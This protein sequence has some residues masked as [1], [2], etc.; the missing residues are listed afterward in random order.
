MTRKG[1]ED[2][3]FD[4]LGAQKR[5]TRDALP[6]PAP[7]PHH[8]RSKANKRTRRCDKNKNQT[9][10]K[11][12]E[13][14]GK[15]ACEKKELHVSSLEHQEEEQHQQKVAYKQATRLE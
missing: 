12:K 7:P 5:A 2:L 11:N 1:P 13:D 8:H 15:I 9:A 10:S 4:Y 3:S 6:T 14:R